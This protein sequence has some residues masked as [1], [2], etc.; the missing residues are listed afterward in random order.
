MA[1]WSAAG[2]PFTAAE[3]LIATTYIEAHAEPAADGT[4]AE[5]DAIAWLCVLTIASFVVIGA[6]HGLVQ[7]RRRAREQRRVRTAD[8]QYLLTR[9]AG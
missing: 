5:A 4:W 8:Q 7:H 3:V 6:L 9:P 1:L 2:I